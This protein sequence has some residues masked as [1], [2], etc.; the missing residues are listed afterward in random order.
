LANFGRAHLD[1][2]GGIE[3]TIEPSAIALYCHQCDDSR[4]FEVDNEERRALK[5]TQTNATLW[6]QLSVKR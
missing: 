4:T 1:H 3:A 5:D 2:L 6:P